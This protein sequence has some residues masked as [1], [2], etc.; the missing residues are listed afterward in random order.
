MYK[1]LLVALIG[2]FFSFSFAANASVLKM[3]CKPS[4]GGG[5]CPA[6]FLYSMGSTPSK[7][8]V[9]SILNGLGDSTYMNTSSV[10]MSGSYC[11]VA[12]GAYICIT[13]S[14]S[15]GSQSITE[16]QS[17]LEKPD[18][19]WCPEPRCPDGSDMPPNGEDFCPVYD[20]PDGS[21]TKDPLSCPATCPDGSTA[22][23]G[24]VSN[25]P[26]N[27]DILN[28]PTDPSCDTEEPPDGYC[29]E[30]QS[31]VFDDCEYSPDDPR[32]PPEEPDPDAHCEQ[33]PD[34]AS[35][36]HELPELP[37]DPFCQKYPDALSCQTPDLP[38]LGG[39]DTGT[40]GGPPAG[41]TGTGTDT[42]GGMSAP[43]AVNDTI[44]NG[45]TT[46]AN[47][48]KQDFK[49]ANR[50]VESRIDNLRYDIAKLHSGL[51]YQT[52]V[53]AKGLTGVG[54]QLQ[55]NGAKVDRSNTL[56]DGINK[57]LDTI[58]GGLKGAPLTEGN[59]DVQGGINTALGITGNESVADLTDAPVRLENY[60][61]E[62][63]PFLSGNQCPEN[64]PISFNLLGSSFTF[65]FYYKPVCDFMSIAGTILNW[66][67]W[68]FVPFIVFGRRRA[69]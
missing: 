56:L 42:G 36:N 69:S 12:S 60:T 40:I 66:A 15:Y 34:S 52:N 1:A 48:N 65:D 39:D 28:G 4:I 61:N 64:I 14:T 45:S 8:V 21:T 30:T 27:C 50:G 49:D 55:A 7:S 63:Q 2:L 57:N 25:C 33:F 23:N 19:D 3:P 53:I 38:D 46:S 47:M 51:N 44:S 20:C 58:S 35:C 59:F 11:Y 22:P 54:K 5:V 9:L 62:F 16:T 31:P 43:G 68:L 18:L 26:I 24:S 32:N 13:H 29:S 10:S 67:V 6:P 37:D 41:G 17:C